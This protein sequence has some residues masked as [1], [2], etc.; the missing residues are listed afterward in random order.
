MLILLEILFVLIS[1]ALLASNNTLWVNTWGRSCVLIP[2]ITFAF[3]IEFQLLLWCYNIGQ[4]NVDFIPQ[5]NIAIELDAPAHG[6]AQNFSDFELGLNI[7]AHYALEIFFLGE[8]IDCVSSS[9]IELARGE[10]E[11]DHKVQHFALRHHKSVHL[12]VAS[13][14]NCIHCHTK[15]IDHHLDEEVFL[16][17]DILMHFVV[18]IAKYLNVKLLAV[19]FAHLFHLF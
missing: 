15:Q 7:S 4:R 5:V 6:I 2:N 14:H 9:V 11:I 13:I 17:G 3:S 10:L 12:D 1:L 19:I 18:N 8:S 16:N